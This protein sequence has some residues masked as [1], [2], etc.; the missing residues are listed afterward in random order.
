FKADDG[1]IL[2]V[3]KAKN[4]KKRVA[5]YFTN[6]KD[7]AYK[8]R[9]LV[10]T[11]DHL[12]F[13]IVHNESD[14]LLLENTLIKRHL[15]RFNVMLKDGKNYTYLCIKNEPFPRVFFTR[16]LIRD[17][18]TYFGPYTSK[19]R[20]KIIMDLIRTLFPIRTCSY[21]LTPENIAKGK[22]KICLEYHIKRCNGPC[23]GLEDEATYLDRIH[24][25]SN[26]LKGNFSEVKR[27]LNAQMEKHVEDLEFEKAHA[28]KEKLAAFEDYQSKSTVVSTA[29]TNVDVFSLVHDEQTAFV[30]YLRIVNGAMIY[31]N[32]FEFTMNLDSEPEDI[33]AYAVDRIME[34]YSSN[35]DEIIVPLAIEVAD[36]S[37]KV[38]VP[39]I[40]DKKKLLDLSMKNAQFFMQQLQQDKATRAKR[41]TKTERVLTTLQQDLHMDKVPFHIECFDNSNIQGSNPVASC[42]VFKNAKPSKSDYRKFN[43][44]TVE[45]PNDFASMKEVVFRRYR[46]MLDEGTDLPEL[47][48]IDGGKGQ[49]NAA[50]E[51]LQELEILQRVTVIGI[52]KRLEE[53]FMPGDPY[54]VY[55]N[56]KSESLILI[57]QIRNEAHRFA[58][59][60]HR[61]QRSKNFIRTELTQIPG[62]GGKTSEKLLK[63]FLSVQRIKQASLA[64]LERVIGKRPAVRVK[65][66]FG[67]DTGEEE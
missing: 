23:E 30:N 26:I 50:V 41:Q 33:L 1:T 14:A 27:H 53:I 12:E 18:S 60:F 52:A 4:I 62:V 51:S 43:I 38:T 7:L 55:I 58:I 8:T 17:G 24:Q 22:F 16:R 34:R 59:T 6:R 40:G 29:V 21:P 37:L 5:S 11:A 46:R 3:G 36:A 63:H 39:K 56:K 42:V 19:A 49:L 45:G 47:I 66:Y 48:V 67:E 65:Q 31:T 25:V 64:E 54:P 2:Y 57:Q 28:V 15:P 9:T 10:K 20:T 13:I 61:N 35:A 44:K 32:T